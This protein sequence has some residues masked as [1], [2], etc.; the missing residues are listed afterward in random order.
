MQIIVLHPRFSARTVTLT[1]RHI[2][3]LGVLFLAAVL[4]VAALLYYLTLAH[5]GS[6]RLPFAGQA[7]AAPS[8]DEAGRKERYV[9]ENLTA[10]AVKLGEMQAQLMRLDALGERVQGLAGVKPEEF[11]FK[12]KPPRG[13]ADPAS[14]GSR[15][16]SRELSMQEFQQTLDALARDLEHRADYLNVVESSLMADKIRFKLLPTIKPV[17]SSYNASSFGWRLDPFSGRSAFHE[18]LDFAAPAGTPIVAAAGGVVIASEYHHQYGNM[19]EIDHGNQLVTRYAH[20]SRL[21]SQVGDIVRRG[22][23]VADL[24]STGR[25]TGAH[26]HFEVLLKGVP[27]DPHKFLIAGG[28]Q[29]KAAALV[30][31]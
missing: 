6:V 23:H 31:R 3:A 13:G 8:Q 24:G 5:A 19:L 4:T 21:L 2:V 7:M 9:R 30:S 12:E 26:L 10:M 28:P 20:A 1:S 14:S 11:N 22:Q 18:G 25:S 16:G 27:Q 17:N 15:G 29:E